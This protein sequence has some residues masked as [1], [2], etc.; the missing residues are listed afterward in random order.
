MTDILFAVASAVGVM[1]TL[2][3]IC[4]NWLPD[5]VKRIVT[6]RTPLVV[7]FVLLVVGIFGP[8]VIS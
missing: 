5:V 8:D 4:S 1:W 7:A 6:A 2:A 3:F